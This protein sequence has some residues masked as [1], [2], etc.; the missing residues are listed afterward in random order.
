MKQLI[1]TRT[2]VKEKN[3]LILN[4]KERGILKAKKRQMKVG[5]KSRKEETGTKQADIILEDQNL[6]TNNKF[7]D[8]TEEVEGSKE[9]MAHQNNTQKVVDD[10]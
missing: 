4:R 5:F 10:S 9:D 1:L 8:L 7:G 2:K 6:N 3:R